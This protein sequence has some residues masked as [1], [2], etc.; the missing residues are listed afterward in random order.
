VTAEPDRDWLAAR[1]EEERAHLRAVAYRML[2]S[3]AEADDAVQDAWLRVARSDAGGVQNLRGWLT[4]IVARLCLDRLRARAARP[5][6][7]VGVHLPDPIVSRLGSAGRAEA[8]DPAAEAVLADSVGLAMLVVLETLTP[9]ER[10]AFV[11]HDTFGLPFEEI[12]PI[13][14]RTTE[15]ARQLASRARRRVRG[16]GTEDAVAERTFGRASPPRQRELVLAFLAAARD[17]DFEALLRLLDPSVV[18]RVDTGDGTSPLGRSRELRGAD[19]V[20]R[21]AFGFRSL[22][23][24]ARLAAINGSPGFVVL[25]ADR[26]YAVLAFG[27]GPESIT[28]IDILADADRLARIDLSAVSG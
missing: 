4:T 22:A 16:A 24:G 12:A 13:V 11:L 15:A 20:A 21:S 17:G 27:F 5:E 8:A 7:P 3:S 28:Q 9:P 6:A 26:P 25:V 1:F 18:A 10:L 23:P 19:V 2:G 14:G